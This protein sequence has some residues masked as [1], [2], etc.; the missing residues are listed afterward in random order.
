MKHTKRQVKVALIAKQK[1][2]VENLEE[3]IAKMRESSDIDE[4]D[5]ASLDDFSHIGEA[6]E[7][8]VRMENKLEGAV[9]ALSILQ[10][11]QMD[12][13]DTV[14][15]GAL[16]ETDIHHF[17]ISLALPTIELDGETIHSIS[18]SSPI[19]QALE[20]KKAGDRV[21]FGEKQYHIKAIY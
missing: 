13:N 7:M 10:D 15:L 3:V 6:E 11:L 17:F 19:Y 18:T 2:I 14:D 9:K 1:E 5:S 4:D 21:P 20:G 8:L 12:T 16:V